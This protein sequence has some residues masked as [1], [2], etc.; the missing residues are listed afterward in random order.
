[1]MNTLSTIVDREGLSDDKVTKRKCL[2]SQVNDPQTEVSRD[3]IGT[4]NADLSQA[5]KDSNSQDWD[6]ASMYQN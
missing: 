1:M 5:A 2:M 3:S 6:Y 4:F